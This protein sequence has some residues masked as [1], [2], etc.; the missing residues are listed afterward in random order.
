[1]SASSVRRS[2]GR[3]AR[4]G[5]G[6]LLVQR[7]RQRLQHRRP[8]VP[9]HATRRP[10]RSISSAAIAVVVVLPLVPVIASTFGA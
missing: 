2:S 7:I 8:D 1:M 6:R 10:A 9:G 4:R 5:R 3:I